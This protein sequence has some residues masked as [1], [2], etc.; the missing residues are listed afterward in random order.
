MI[1]ICY[2]AKGLQ[3]CRDIKKDALTYFYLFG[4][5]EKSFAMCIKLALDDHVKSLQEEQAMKAPIENDTDKY[6]PIEGEW[7]TPF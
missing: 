6:L 2:Q 4:G 3:H 5:K 7:G 1:M